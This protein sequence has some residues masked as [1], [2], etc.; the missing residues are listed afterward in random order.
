[1]HQKPLVLLQRL[2]SL[3]HLTDKADERGHRREVVGGPTD[4][5]VLLHTV[6]D[7]VLGVQVGGREGGR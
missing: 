1:M 7:A 4:E 2:H 6:G 3:Q 5:L